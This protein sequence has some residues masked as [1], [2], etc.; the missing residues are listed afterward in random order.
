MLKTLKSLPLTILLSVLIWMYAEAQFTNTQENVQLS[1]KL[2][3]PSP[4][5]TLRAID[6]VRKRVTDTM[7]A[8][9]TLQGPRNQ[10]DA[11]YQQSQ[12]VADEELASLSW[13]PRQ[14]DLHPGEATTVDMVSMLNSLNYFRDRRVTIISAAP[15]RVTLQVDQML[16]LSKAPDFRP[17]APLE[18][19]VLSED[20]VTVN[21]PAA[22]LDQLGG[23]GKIAVV[24]EPQR[25][26]ATLPAGTDQ[27][28]PVKYVA[29]YPGPRDDRITITPPAGTVTVRIAATTAA[30]EQVPDVPVWASGPPTLLGKYDIDIKPRLVRVTVAGTPAAIAAWHAQTNDPGVRAYVDL[31][32]DD[33]VTDVAIRR[34]IRYVLPDG[35]TLQGAPGDVEFRLTPKA[36][37]VPA[38]A[39][40]LAPAATQ[41][42][43][44]GGR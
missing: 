8:V 34:R 40:A 36:P 14:A 9:V 6:P 26:L 42:A 20:S 18:R 23:P 1:V 30:T 39:P 25:S 32:P 29:D 15:P 16:H 41:G 27:T 4:E 44:G 24:A 12:G 31:T 2:V 38:P 35:L 13:V 5:L 22:A 17:A 11:I 10:L 19:A 28:I 43:G 33:G 7:N 3:T 37:P 21:V